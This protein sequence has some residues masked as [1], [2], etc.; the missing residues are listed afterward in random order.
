MRAASALHEPFSSL[1]RQREAASFGI[2]IFL[3]SEMLFFGAL[4][5]GYAV[6]RFLY[7]Q[8][9]EAAA[10]E[11]SLVHGTV[12][13]FL[14]LTS[15]ATMAIAVEVAAQAMGEDH[16]DVGRD[17]DGHRRR[18]ARRH[19]LVTLSA[20]ALLG[21]A[22]LV[23]K[24]FEYHDDLGKHLLPADASFPI[25]VVGGRIFWSFYWLLTGI[26]AL[27][28]TIGIGAVCT[29][30]FAVGTRR[31]DWRRTATLHVLG[32]YWHLVDI[33]WVVLFP[34]LYLLGR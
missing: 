21:L 10:A 12:N 7:S 9:F 6:Y 17:A 32:L 18:D 29:V 34:L 28:L 23:V 26:H 15:S 4:L 24:G 8:G 11:A 19:V 22:F 2:W 16:G 25:D 20:T 27:H 3:A 13:T 14:L 5:L 30:L 1:R 31:F 33:V